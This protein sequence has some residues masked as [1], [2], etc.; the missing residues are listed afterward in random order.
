MGEPGRR[1]LSGPKQGEVDVAAVELDDQSAGEEALTA[2][3]LLSCPE[4]QAARRERGAL[5]E[6]GP[7]TTTASKVALRPQY[8]TCLGFHFSE[9]D[10]RGGIVIHDEEHVLQ[11]EGAPLEL[12]RG[13]TPRPRQVQTIEVTEV[14]EEQGRECGLQ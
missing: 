10:A 7:Q 9:I 3:V 2:G 8:A 5:T 4:N 14:G 12:V 13:A 6:V 11:Q 1:S